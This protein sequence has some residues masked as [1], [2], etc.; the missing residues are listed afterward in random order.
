MDQPPAEVVHRIL[1]AKDDFF[2]ECTG[3]SAK[4]RYHVALRIFGGTILKPILVVALAFSCLWSTAQAAEPGAEAKTALHAIVKAQHIEERWRS[5]LDSAAQRNANVMQQT[6]KDKVNAAPQLSQAQRKQ[7]LALLPEWTAAVAQ[8]LKTLD[9][10]MDMSALI[11]EMAHT[12]YPRF[13]TDREITALAAFYSSSAYRKTIDVGARIKEEQ[14]RTGVS[15][16]AAW[17]KYKH[18]FTE[19]ENDVILA[20]GRSDVGKKLDRVGAAMNQDV[21]RFFGAKTSASISAIAERHMKLF[22]AEMNAITAQ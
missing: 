16:P 8:D 6:V 14:R 18:L 4:L 17:D 9:R 19:Q 22:V 3:A 20:H 12:V 13:F 15:D 5:Y 7:A 10:S 11:G 21:L 2:G 1:R